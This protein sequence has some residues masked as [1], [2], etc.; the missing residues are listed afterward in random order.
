LSCCRTESARAVAPGTAGIWSFDA[1]RKV[2][3]AIL[4]R[5]RYVAFA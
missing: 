2:L 4:S 5:K 1:M 3:P